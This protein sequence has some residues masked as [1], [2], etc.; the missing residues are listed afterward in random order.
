MFP[1]TSKLEDGDD[2]Q[3]FLSRREFEE[4]V[5]ENGWEYPIKIRSYFNTNDGEFFSEILE[6][7]KFYK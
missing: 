2:S 4:F 6:L 7:D 5:D 1:I 3:A